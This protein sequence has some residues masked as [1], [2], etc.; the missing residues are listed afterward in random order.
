LLN[1][2]SHVLQAVPPDPPQQQHN[3]VHTMPMNLHKF[4]PRIAQPPTPP[5]QLSVQKQQQQQQQPI[6]AP[7][8]SNAPVATVLPQGGKSYSAVARAKAKVTTPVSCLFCCRF[9]VNLLFHHFH[10][11]CN[12]IIT[13][14]S[15]RILLVIILQ[16]LVYLLL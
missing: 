9:Y 6:F 5:E 15:V 2:L 7:H 11:F 4:E 3:I 13:F 8:A 12:F 10:N 14:R 1:N 16:L